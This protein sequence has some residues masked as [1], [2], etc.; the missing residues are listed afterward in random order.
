MLSLPAADLKKNKVLQKQKKTIAT[1]ME[2]G[3]RIELCLSLL[4]SGSAVCLRYCISCLT[5][6]K[7]GKKGKK[8]YK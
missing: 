7:R 2:V 8:K 6:G 4:Y 5:T 3:G 1:S